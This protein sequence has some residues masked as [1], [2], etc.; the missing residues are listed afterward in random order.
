MARPRSRLARAC[1]PMVHC[2]PRLGCALAGA[3]R[4]GDGLREGEGIGLRE[5]AGRRRRNDLRCVT[6]VRGEHRTSTFRA[7]HCGRPAR[8]ERR[9]RAPPRRRRRPVFRRSIPRRRR[10]ATTCAARC[11]ATSSRPRRSCSSRRASAYADGAPTALPEERANVDKYRERIA[12]LR[13]AIGVHEKNVEAL[14]KELA[15]AQ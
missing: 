2:V 15:S 6:G 10:V 14:R 13:Q 3:A 9:A 11:W 8:Y 5:Q 12:R 7:R 1:R 4:R